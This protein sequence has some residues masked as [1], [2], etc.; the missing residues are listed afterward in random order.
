ML[1]KLLQDLLLK[2]KINIC[3]KKKHEIWPLKLYLEHL[4]HVEILP[5]LYTR[6][7]CP[8]QDSMVLQFPLPNFPLAS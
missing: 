5:V 6:R 2:K 3:K 7:S 4:G 1:L 8:N